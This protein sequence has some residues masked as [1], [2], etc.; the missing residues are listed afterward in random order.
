[1]PNPRVLLIGGHG[2]ISLLL[3]PKLL[4]RS[5]DVISLIRSSSQIADIQSAAALAPSSSQGKIE[6]LVRSIEDVKSEADARSILDEAKADWVVWS[7][8]A[9]GKG[10]QE[11]TYAV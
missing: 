8:G 6:T 5:F 9:G 1:M 4:S 3:T 11:R 7:A 10:G 2:R